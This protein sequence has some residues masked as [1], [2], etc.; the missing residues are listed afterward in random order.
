MAEKNAYPVAQVSPGQ[1]EAIRR[2]E[3]QLSREQGKNVVLIAYEE[4]SPK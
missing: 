1:V 2:L 3:E 4:K